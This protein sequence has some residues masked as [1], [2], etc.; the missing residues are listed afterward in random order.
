[1]GVQLGA[2][3]V[4]LFTAFLVL[5]AKECARLT[6]TARSFANGYFLAFTLGCCANSLLLNF[7]EGYLF[8]F[9]IGLMIATAPRAIDD[10]P[11]AG[12]SA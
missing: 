8:V 2:I 1:M 3:G 9:L 11:A 7:T 10:I 12:R 4:A 5:L 6:G